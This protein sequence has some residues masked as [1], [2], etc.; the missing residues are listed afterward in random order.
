MNL[1]VDNKVDLGKLKV[2]VR[3]HFISNMQQTLKCLWYLQKSNFQ[4]S[5]KANAWN[6]INV[7]ISIKRYCEF[8]VYFSFDDFSGILHI[9]VHHHIIVAGASMAMA[10]IKFSIVQSVLPVYIFAFPTFKY[11]ISGDCF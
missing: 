9:Y 11:Q 5:S 4:L 6:K 3:V 10:E 1:T 7:F 8:Q 2:A